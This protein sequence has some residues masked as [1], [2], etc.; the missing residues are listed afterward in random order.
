MIYL[1][2]CMVITTLMV[3]MFKWFQIFN[4]NTNVALTIN[5]LVAGSFAATQLDS[6]PDISEIESKPYLPY[7]LIIGFLFMM[8]FVLMAYTAQKSGPTIASVSARMSLVLPVMTGILYFGESA[9]WLKIAG[10]VLTVPAVYL[11]SVKDASGQQKNKWG[12]LLPPMLFLGSG[13]I[14]TVMSISQKETGSADDPFFIVLV[15]FFAALT[16]VF[17]LLFTKGF[18]PIASPG[19]TIAG[20]LIL[21]IVNFFSLYTMLKA[22]GSNEMESSVLY[23][24]NNIGIII[25]TAIASVLIFREKLSWKNQLGI[26]LAA[27][28]ILLTGWETIFYG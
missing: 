25:T 14:D 6:F 21:G 17:Y 24:F 9:T 11:S 15:F 4:V 20:G 22:L 1:L 12:W 5:Y 27:L 7:A 19:R 26:G 16:G 10:F 3:L 8:I 18:S 13:I 28:A 23:A 2:L